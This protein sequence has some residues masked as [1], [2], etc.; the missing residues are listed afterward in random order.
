MDGC[1]SGVLS[2]CR[3]CRPARRRERLRKDVA[4]CT[5]N[6]DARAGTYTGPPLPRQNCHDTGARDISGACKQPP[7]HSAYASAHR[8]WRQANTLLASEVSAINA[9]TVAVKLENGVV[10]LWWI[11]LHNDYHWVSSLDWNHRGWL[12]D[13]HRGLSLQCDWSLCPILEPWNLSRTFF[14]LYHSSRIC[15]TVREDL[16]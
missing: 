15:F 9:T 1:W 10:I 6:R 2:S 5:C 7:G 12:M 4:E 13:L 14:S 8:E 3:R 11:L 16:H